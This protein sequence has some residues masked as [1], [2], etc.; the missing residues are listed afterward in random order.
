MKPET[1]STK[2]FN[3]RELQIGDTVVFLVPNGRTLVVGEC[4]GWT[5]Q[6]VRI[7]YMKDVWPH[8]TAPEETFIT[9]PAHV[10]AKYTKE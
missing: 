5:D 8:K 7:K 9:R 6:S 1:N 10:V 4:I 3:G 2:D